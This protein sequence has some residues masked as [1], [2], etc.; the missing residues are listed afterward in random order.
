MSDKELMTQEVKNVEKLSQAR[1][2]RW[3]A[4]EVDIFETADEVVVQAD[5]P[6]IQDDHLK[7]EVNR[8]LLT[9]EA[10]QGQEES[11]LG[12]YRQFRI[13]DRVNA[14]AADAALKDG[15]LTLRLPKSEAA[16]PR[17]ISVKTLH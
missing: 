5:L 2:V 4:P 14:D 15:V 3:A 1:P 17:R 8:G 10:T 13:S 7:I 6:G 16:K 12:F 9:L 11:G